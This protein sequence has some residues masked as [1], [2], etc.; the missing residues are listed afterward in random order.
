[1]TFFA[2]VCVKKNKRCANI[3]MEYF[4]H[5]YV[6]INLSQSIYTLEITFLIIGIAACINRIRNKRIHAPW[7]PPFLTLHHPPTLESSTRQSKNDCSPKNCTQLD[8][9]PLD[10]LHN[11]CMWDAGLVHSNKL[12]PVLVELT[13]HHPVLH[14][15]TS[16]KLK[17]IPFKYYMY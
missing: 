16:Y 7:R 2:I 15:S 1:M 10:M 8:S 12:K 9:L 14:A 11:I 5:T 17:Y 6:C 3:L 4:G 13:Q